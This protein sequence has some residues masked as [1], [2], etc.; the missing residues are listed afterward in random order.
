MWLDLEEK[1][2][3]LIWGDGIQFKATPFSQDVIVLTDNG[4]RY[5]SAIRVMRDGR[6]NDK[7]I[8]NHCRPLCQ[9]NPNGI[10]W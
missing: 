4:N 3:E 8:V 5:P 2:V 7:F 10:I 6:M 9:A 1:G